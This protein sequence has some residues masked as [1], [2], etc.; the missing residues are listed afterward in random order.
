MIQAPRKVSL[1]LLREG[2]TH[3]HLLSPLTPYLAVVGR[4]E[5]AS[6]RVPY[7]HRRLLRDL[8]ALRYGASSS[9]APDMSRIHPPDRRMIA[10]DV[11]KIFEAVP[12]LTAELGTAYACHPELVHLELVF[13]ASELSLLP[14]ELAT[15]PRGFP[16]EGLPLSIQ[17][18][19]PIVITRTIPSANG[20]ECGWGV[21]PKLLFAWASPRGMPEVPHRA[22]LAALISALAPWTGPLED[23]SSAE[24]S[25][26][27]SKYLTVLPHASRGQI[28]R[29]CRTHGFTHIHLL[30]HGAAREEGA[31]SQYSIALDDGAGA[32]EMVNAERLQAALRLP[33][34]R[35]DA[36]KTLS[37]P[38]VVSLATCDSG[39]Q[40]QVVL[41]GMSLAHAIHAA[42]VPLVVGS[43]FPITFRGSVT[44]TE[45][46]YT[47]LLRGRDPR[48]VLYDTRH[49]LFRNDDRTHDWASMVAYASLADD[50]SSQ[51]TDL[52]YLAA[53]TTISARTKLLAKIAAEL[54]K[55]P[56]DSAL[57]DKLNLHDAEILIAQRDLP[58]DQAYLIEGRGMLASSEKKRAQ[59][60]F[61]ATGESTA[62]AE[63]NEQDQALLKRSITALK[64][65]ERI[66]LRT[67]QV[68]PWAVQRPVLGKEKVPTLHWVLTQAL[69]LGFVLHRSLDFTMWNAAVC[70][71]KLLL[72]NSEP[73]LYEDMLPADAIWAH[74]SLLELYLLAHS[75]HAVHGV[76][77]TGGDY[78]AL[79]LR[80]LDAFLAAT[81]NIDESFFLDSTRAQLTR[82]VTWWLD[83]RFISACGHGE[84]PAGDAAR[85]LVQRLLE[86]LKTPR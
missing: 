23:L 65:A 30:A 61:E 76:D 54:K 68:P 10:D 67:A 45:R 72:P 73:L 59:A 26:A 66:Y 51:A 49:E 21:P 41:P 69:S 39:N 62:D 86:R 31:E 81:E 32:T 16:G 48:W 15:A 22:H 58:Q 12:G 33:L 84:D 75:R 13:S 77:F 5:A 35:P 18:T 71:A 7:E 82:Y 78:E 55:A 4:H 79:A 57:H 9:T 64:N 50:I 53:C 43:L 70:N 46:L 2:P 29:L 24:R 63:L 42:G 34:D 40:A 56:D 17:V 1:R 74:G 14:F 8:T 36:E 27:V 11:G 52:R 3:N 83:P 28:E 44:L 19:T 25:A 6:V 80:E 60:L 20:R 38:L 47:G 37:H 85:T